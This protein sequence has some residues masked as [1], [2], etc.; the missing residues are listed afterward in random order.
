MNN[1]KF[2]FYLSV[3]T[4]VLVAYLAYDLYKKNKDASKAA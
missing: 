2:V 4:A 1:A 3:A